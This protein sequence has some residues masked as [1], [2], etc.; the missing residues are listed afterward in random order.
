MLAENSGGSDSAKFDVVIKE[1]PTAP[2]SV[3][4]VDQYK[5]FITV[6]WDAPS[7]DGGAPITGYILEKRDAARTT[8]TQVAE[9]GPDMLKYKV[10]KLFEGNEYLF[11][12]AAQNTI[13]LG[14]YGQI[15]DGVIA[16]LPF[17]VPAAPKELSIEDLTRKMVVLAWDAPEFNGGSPITGYYVERRQAYTNRWTRVN[18]TPLSTTMF[19]IKD[20]IEDDEYEFRVV[21]ENDAGDSK[22]SETTGIFT[23]RDP[24]SKPGKPSQPEVTMQR[25]TATV[26][27]SVPR[28]DGHSPITGYAVEMK[29]AGDIRW[30]TVTGEEHTPQT[31]CKVMSLRPDMDYEFRVSAIN[32]AGFSQPSQASAPVRYGESCS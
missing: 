16:K 27:W 10:T 14:T 24:Y 8:W 6:A 30:K 23:A 4:M 26:T 31:S 17:G 20:L 12:V 13:G 21:A 7:S 1:K 18:K 5:D 2:Q 19:T 22:P 3:R 15:E 11:R 29:A 25:D 9:V 28:D 32:K